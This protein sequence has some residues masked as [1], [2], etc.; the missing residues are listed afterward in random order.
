[1][2][3]DKVINNALLLIY[4]TIVSIMVV[5]HESWFDEAQSWLIARDLSPLEIIYQMKYEG[6]PFLWHYILLPFAKL[7]F[8]YIT[9]NIISAL[10]CIVSAVILIKKSPFNSFVK[11]IILFSTPF[12]YYAFVARSYCL[13]VLAIVL[14][15]VFYKQ[16]EKRP[17]LYG[18]L[19][20]LLANTH[21]IMLGMAIMLVCTEYLY[22]I[23]FKK[24]N[25]SKEI[26]KKHYIG[27]VI[28]SIGILV[29]VIIAVVGSLTNPNVNNN[30][31]GLLRIIKGFWSSTVHI[32]SCLSPSS[33]A[34]FLFAGII[35]LSWIL[36]K[37]N[38]KVAL[39]FL[40]S[41]CF[42]ILVSTTKYGLAAHTIYT[43]MLILVFCFWIFIERSPLTD[44]KGIIFVLSIVIMFGTNDI[45]SFYMIKSDIFYNYSLSKEC[46]EFINN[47]LEG[48][49][50]ICCLDD[51][52]TA[53]IIPYLEER[54]KIFCL[55]TNQ[56][57]SFITHN[58]E[59]TLKKK[60]I[61]SSKGG[62]ILE[63]ALLTGNFDYYIHSIGF[64]KNEDKIEE[65]KS[66]QI[67]QEIYCS[68]N[69]GYN[70]EALYFTNESY[71]IF[72]INK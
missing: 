53:S 22:E 27:L 55:T 66:K 56:Y 59:S 43:V 29:M 63:K 50:Q 11:M 18:V 67:L 62:E 51:T 60:Q 69:S 48:D 70:S 72:K 8:P 32:I 39:I 3:K 4:V 52:S 2:T 31:L 58:Y 28:A 44:R 45:L 54:D 26:L 9:K 36:Y 38:Y 24:N 1:M 5:C 30:Q 6:H 13:V 34:I 40:G 10:I 14:L 71:R 20:C 23:I 68:T 41:I 65:L 25:Y 33:V 61:K 19:I 57:S 49:A 7:G 37:R 17:V 21:V 15:A 46:G 42:V 47:N 16:R 64:L 12:I 35:S